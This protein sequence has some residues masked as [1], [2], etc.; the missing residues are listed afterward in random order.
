MK[1]KLIKA[2]MLSAIVLSS[3]SENEENPFEIP[4]FPESAMS[5]IHGDSQ[6]SWRITGFVNKYHDPNY[7]L[8]IELPCLEDDVYTFSSID[9]HF[10]VDLGDDKCFGTN[11]DG[12][13]TADVEIFD[14]ELMFMDASKGETIYLRYSRGY[15]NDD[16]TAGGVSIR[17]FA[18]AELTENRMVFYRE[19]AKYIGKYKEALIFEAVDTS[20]NN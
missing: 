11:D 3:C 19:N 13:F 15:S 18:L 9:N 4:L 7:D 10:T 17:F 5:I 1:N 16:S 2:L 12:I 6:K 8:E 14:G 20:I